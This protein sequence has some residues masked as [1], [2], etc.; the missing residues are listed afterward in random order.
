MRTARDEIGSAIQELTPEEERFQKS[1]KTR[2]II[3]DPRHSRR[4]RFFQFLGS[5][6]D[7][8]IPGFLVEQVQNRYE[9]F[10]VARLSGIEGDERIDASQSREIEAELHQAAAASVDG[11]R[12]DFQSETMSIAD[13]LL[14]TIVIDQDDFPEQAIGNILNDLAQIG[15]PVV[16]DQTEKAIRVARDGI[17]APRLGIVSNTLEG[18]AQKRTIVLESG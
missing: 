12:D 7:D 11:S 18:S 8:Q 15:G 16:R 4:T 2:S 9:T 3:I 10:E 13:D 17:A 5:G 14:G 1:A 6:A